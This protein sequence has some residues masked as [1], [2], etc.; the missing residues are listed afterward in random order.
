VIA[1]IDQS[2]NQSKSNMSD[3]MYATFREAVKFV[4]QV[5]EEFVTQ[6]NTYEA[7]LRLLADYQ[8]SK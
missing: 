8:H 6:P 4:R 3:S 5:K 1:S 2:I 7:F